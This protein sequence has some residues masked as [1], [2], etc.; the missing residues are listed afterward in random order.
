MTA[1]PK[2]LNIS[3]SETIIMGSDYALCIF[4]SVKKD[5]PSPDLTLV[6][7]DKRGDRYKLPHPRAL[8]KYGMASLE[9]CLISL[10]YD[11]SHYSISADEGQKPCLEPLRDNGHPTPHFSISHSGE[12]ALCIL[13]TKAPVGADIELI[14][15]TSERLSLRL[16]IA[17]RSFS[18]AERLCLNNSS[19]TDLEFVRIW[20]AHEAVGKCI[21]VGFYKGDATEGAR[22][23]GLTLHE[24]RLTVKNQ[25]YFLTLCVPC[26]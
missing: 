4:S 1:L 26:K 15:G 8:S 19:E 3:E 14:P 24:I 17:K 6:G 23:H 16:G 11:P 7:A 25:E 9:K 18:E 20:C 12:V 22:L 13:S 21:G 2:N 5:S 10:G